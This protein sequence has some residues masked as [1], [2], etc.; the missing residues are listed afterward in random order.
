MKWRIWTVSGGRIQMK[1]QRDFVAA[2]VL[3]SVELTSSGHAQVPNQQIPSQY[4]DAQAV[5]IAILNRSLG[6]VSNGQRQF[7][8]DS[9]VT[10]FIAL[11]RGGTSIVEPTQQQVC[12]AWKRM[13]PEQPFTGNFSVAGAEFSLDKFCAIK[14]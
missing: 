7:S 13:P 14:R 10:R 9:P 4:E 11:V 5:A 1:F 12:D 3:T 6:S 2:I 8:A